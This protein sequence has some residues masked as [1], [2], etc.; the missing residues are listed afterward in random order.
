LVF[1]VVSG[2]EVL[3]HIEI[4]HENS[5][6]CERQSLLP[7]LWFSTSIGRSILIDKVPFEALHKLYQSQRQLIV[8]AI[9]K[10]KIFNNQLNYLSAM[11]KSKFLYSSNDFYYTICI[12]GNN[13]IT[14][15]RI[16]KSHDIKGV[17]LSNDFENINFID[18]NCINIIV[19]T[20]PGEILHTKM[21]TN[22]IHFI[23]LILKCYE[24]NIIQLI[25]IVV[26]TDNT[27]KSFM[28]DTI[29][30]IDEK[31]S[32]LKDFLLTNVFTLSN[33]DM[34]RISTLSDHSICSNE[35]IGMT[36]TT[37]QSYW[38]R[39]LIFQ[40]NATAV[41]QTNSND[42]LCAKFRSI[43]I[44][45]CGNCVYMRHYGQQA[46]DVC[47]SCKPL[48]LMQECSDRSLLLYDNHGKSLHCLNLDERLQQ[49]LSFI[50]RGLFKYNEKIFLNQ[51]RRVIQSNVSSVDINSYEIIGGLLFIIT[52]RDCEHGANDRSE[53]SS[54]Q[55][56]I[57]NHYKVE[58]EEFIEYLDLC[59]QFICRGCRSL[60]DI[61]MIT[62]R[63]LAIEYLPVGF[64]DSLFS[65][66]E[67]SVLRTY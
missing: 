11:K 41:T 52:H 60:E 13:C 47:N 34:I 2:G 4:Y 7:S 65:V 28:L 18:S 39:L 6:E 20:Y 27:F 26:C 53:V 67:V 31:Q 35:D 51:L 50:N 19:L 21:E 10:L 55:D 9:K 42:N 46:V 45:G 58:D 33:D 59:L 15:H 44:F 25:K 49:N 12:D 43:I 24:N 40:S 29:N 54:P 63:L 16:D 61:L 17:S 64:I 66:I 48:P 57:T 36:N 8:P 38:S 32:V 5:S 37:N 22:G 62:H 30:I 1:A 56:I 23:K 3:N 14:I